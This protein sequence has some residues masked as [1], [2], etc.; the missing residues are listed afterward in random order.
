LREGERERDEMRFRDLRIEHETEIEREMDE[1]GQEKRST[2]DS[3]ALGACERVC[4][5]AGP[6]EEGKM[7]PRSWGRGT[8]DSPIYIFG[9]S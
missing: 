6:R 9:R 3:I 5:H 7:R 1:R 8:N 4:T 2:Q